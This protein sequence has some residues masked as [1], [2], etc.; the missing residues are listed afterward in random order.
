VTNATPTMQRGRRPAPSRRSA[1]YFAGV[2][3]GL[4]VVAAGLALA[5]GGGRSGDQNTVTGFEPDYTD[6]AAR[7]QAAGVSTM[8]N[9]QDATAHFHPH[10][11]LYLNGDGIPIPTNVGIDPS[12]S[13]EAMASLH[14]HSSDG[15]IHVEGMSRATLG[16][17]FEIW[18]VT[19]SKAQLGPYRAS[20]DRV[21][22]M[23]VD[24][25]RSTAFGEQQLAD[26]QRIVIAF[27]PK[28][29]PPPPLG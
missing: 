24:G 4:A 13:P 21:V 22:R 26:G 18:G 9:P 3:V 28:D 27:G 10:L 20:G 1:A 7:E 16:Q 6:L 12:A 8:G 17:L 14:T 23:W 25:K 19:F 2:V 15:T 11:S 5:L 29:S